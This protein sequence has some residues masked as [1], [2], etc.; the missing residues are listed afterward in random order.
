[1]MKMILNFRD[2]SNRLSTMKKTR[3][4]NYVTNCKDAVYVEYE[5]E[6]P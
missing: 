1:M 4:D 2:Q 6:L 5:I 3:Y